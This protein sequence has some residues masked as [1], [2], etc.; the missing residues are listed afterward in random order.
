LAYN[1]KNFI[2]FYDSVVGKINELNNH[3]FNNLSVIS[4]PYLTIK[5]SYLVPVVQTVKEKILVGK[6]SELQ[7][8]QYD[9]FN[10]QIKNQIRDY[11]Q[12]HKIAADKVELI[13]SEL[14]DLE[15]GLTFDVDCHFNTIPLIKRL[16]SRFSV[17]CTYDIFY[18][19]EKL[20]LD[21]NPYGNAYRIKETQMLP[22]T[23]PVFTTNFKQIKLVDKHRNQIALN[24]FNKM[25]RLYT[26][27]DELSQRKKDVEVA[28]QQLSKIQQSIEN[29]SFNYTI[30]HSEYKEAMKSL[31][32]KY[33]HLKQKLIDETRALKQ[34]NF[35]ILNK[36]RDDCKV[37]ANTAVQNKKQYIQNA[38][39]NIQ[40]DSA[41]NR[42]D[43][44]S[45]NSCKSLL[46]RARKNDIVLCEIIPKTEP[47]RYEV[48]YTDSKHRSHIEYLRTN[49]YEN[50]GA[51]GHTQC[52]NTL[53]SLC[54]RFKNNIMEQKQ[55]AQA[56]IQNQ[57]HEEKE[58]RQYYDSESEEED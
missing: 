8:L 50:I 11:A 20:L 18:S 42:N 45:F 5:P 36:V 38:I 34:K 21:K 51:Q 30:Q 28:Q 35:N 55:R 9:L 41:V 10:K 1:Y 37:A 15:S 52:L 25:L 43:L 7:A 40:V 47:N 33:A 16:G 14:P 39:N 54:Y 31:R 22:Q 57:V 24:R 26:T 48:R 17:Q 19:G 29:E 3:S 2:T 44:M 32:Q 58:S 49:E 4:C 6:I 46:A 53:Q 12:Q 56:A 13:R 23:K 27:Q